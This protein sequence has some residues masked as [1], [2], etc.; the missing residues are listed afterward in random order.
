MPGGG[1]SCSE[2]IQPTSHFPPSWATCSMVTKA[3]ANLLSSFLIIMSQIWQS[4]HIIRPRS[5]WPAKPPFLSTYLL[6]KR[7]LPPKPSMVVGGVSDGFSRLNA[8]FATLRRKSPFLLEKSIK[9]FSLGRA[10]QREGGGGTPIAVL[11]DE[12]SNQRVTGA[13]PVHGVDWR[14]GFL[15]NDSFQ[16]T[17]RTVQGSKCGGGTGRY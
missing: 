7:A 14:S 16:L 13:T 6:D 3:S 11:T 1:S 15:T 9:S 2:R 10:F 5:L 8:F 4:S 12:V 17:S